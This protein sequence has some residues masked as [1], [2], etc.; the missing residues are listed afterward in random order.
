[1]IRYIRVARSI[2][3]AILSGGFPSANYV[4]ELR[5]W[6]KELNRVTAPD[7]DP[8]SD[9]FELQDGIDTARRLQTKPDK[10]WS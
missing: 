3:R 5:R 1:M 6:Q 2:S 8:F 7:K 9:P 4:S 10:N